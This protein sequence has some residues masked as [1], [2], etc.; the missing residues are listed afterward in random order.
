MPY[1]VK[2]YAGSALALFVKCLRTVPD[3]HTIDWAPH[4]VFSDAELL[5]ALKVPHCNRTPHRIPACTRF[6]QYRRPA[7]PRAPHRTLHRRART[8]LRWLTGFASAL[9]VDRQ[10]AVAMPLGLQVF[11]TTGSGKVLALTAYWGTHRVLMGYSRSTH[12]VL[13]GYSL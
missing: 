1:A 12:G 7:P 13:N 5:E 9:T 4:S 6:A 2:D 8:F 11:D 10:T 3:V